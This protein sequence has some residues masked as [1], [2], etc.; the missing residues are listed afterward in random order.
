MTR[1]DI[2]K[3]KADW[4]ERKCDEAAA[5]SAPWALGNLRLYQNLASKFWG[6][7]YAALTQTETNP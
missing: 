7:Y 2:L 3:R 5:S 1:T 6:E 4:A